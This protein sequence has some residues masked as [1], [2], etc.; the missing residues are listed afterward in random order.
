MNVTSGV[1]ITFA[2]RK[3]RGNASCLLP[4]MLL[5]LAFVVWVVPQFCLSLKIS[6]AISFWSA[7]R[8]T[9]GINNSSRR[10]PEFSTEPAVLTKSSFLSA[11]QSPFNDAVQDDRLLPSELIFPTHRPILAIITETD[12]CDTEGKMEHTYATVKKAVSTGKVD[13]V[14]V[15]LSLPPQY[16]ENGEE[17]FSYLEILERSNRLTKKLVELSLTRS[18][19]RESRHTD[20][21][22][23]P[24]SP[25]AFVVVCSSDLVSVAVNARANGVHVKEHHLD[26]LPDIVSRFDYPIVIGT[27]THSVESALRSH[28]YNDDSDK[29]NQDENENDGSPRPTATRPKPHYYFVG[30]CYLTASHPEKTSQSQLE[31]PGLPG[32]VKEALLASFESKGRGAITATD[33]SHEIA[34]KKRALPL[35]FP[36]I[37]AIGGIDET[38]CREPVALGADGVAVIRAVFQAD[39]PVTRV[40][41]M[42]RNMRRKNCTVDE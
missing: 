15:R 38:N 16:D 28:F 13:L 11:S 23:Q 17:N 26:K 37:M 18:R 14:S 25:F 9:G 6:D 42:Q 7:Q 35:H 2:P 29:S 40:E 33:C 8:N 1:E 32:R 31:G 10:R 24:R 20:R 4:A 12:A 41:E 5:S 39:C 3:R 34:L 27:S 36:R 30:T 21:S 22:Q 19:R